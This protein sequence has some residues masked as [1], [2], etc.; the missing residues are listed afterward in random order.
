MRPEIAGLI[1]GRPRPFSRRRVFQE[2]ARND[3]W[4][5][6]RAAGYRPAV[7]GSSGTTQG[8]RIEAP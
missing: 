4:K 5:T 8:K 2:S 1:P 3:R 7:A 6:R